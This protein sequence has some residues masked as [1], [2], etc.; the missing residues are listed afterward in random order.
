MIADEA[1]RLGISA[2]EAWKLL[3][4]H[5]HFRYPDLGVVFNVL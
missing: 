3:S 2:H 4:H 5:D 1:R